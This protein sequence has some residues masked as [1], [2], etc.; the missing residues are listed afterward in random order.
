MSFDIPSRK[1]KIYDDG[2]KEFSATTI[3]F[4]GEAVVGIL[5]APEATANQDLYVSSFTTCGNEILASFEKATGQKWEVERVS[6]EEEASE[7]RAKMARGDRSGFLQLAKASLYGLGH[8][9]DIV[10]HEEDLAN[11]VLGLQKESLD[12]VIAGLVA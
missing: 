9:H 8:G 10:F 5:R 3:G 1:A 11:S 6:S 2:N 4:V 12:D 7:G